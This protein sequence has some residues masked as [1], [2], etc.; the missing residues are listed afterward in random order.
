MRAQAHTLE[1]VTA[2]I[3]ILGAVVFAL[4]ITAVTPLSASTSSQH[5][6][7]QLAATSDGVLTSTE[8]S[9]A[10]RRAVLYWDE[11]QAQFHGA[12][13]GPYYTNDEAIDNTTFGRRLVEAFADRSIAFNVRIFYRTPGGMD[14]IRF[15][16]RGEPSDNAVTVTRM[17]TLYDDDVLYADDPSDGVMVALPT[18]QNVSSAPSFYAPDVASGSGVY[19]VLRVEVVVWRM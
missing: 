17:L 16:Y 3:L 14:D 7:N 18:E 9:G 12:D 6:E 19:N 4:Q 8:E 15:V 13:G 10:L 5:I 2:A 11:P 1:A